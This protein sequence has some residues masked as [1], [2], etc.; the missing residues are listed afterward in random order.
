MAIPVGRLRK[1]RANGEDTT[2]MRKGPG[3]SVTVP[4]FDC[5]RFCPESCYKDPAIA[6]A[7]YVTRRSHPRHRTESPA[8]CRGV[9]QD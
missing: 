8:R 2:V 4:G 5:P 7:P 9:A 6:S 1:P 3:E